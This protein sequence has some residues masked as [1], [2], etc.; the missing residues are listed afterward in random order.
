MNV[1]NARESQIRLICNDCYEE[2]P[3]D[4]TGKELI[5]KF[6]KGLYKYKEQIG[7]QKHITLD[8]LIDEW[9]QELKD[10]SS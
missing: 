5:Q 4:A 3:P 8:L 9:E 10:I 1:F 2:R 7:Y 6:L